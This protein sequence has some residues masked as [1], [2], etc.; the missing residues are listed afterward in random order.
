[1]LDVHSVV[2]DIPCE[3]DMSEPLE[4]VPPASWSFLSSL[5]PGN[6]GIIARATITMQIFNIQNHPDYPMTAYAPEGDPQKGL[7][8]IWKP[9]C[10]ILKL[11][12]FVW[13]Y[14]NFLFQI[15][16]TDKLIEVCVFSAKNDTSILK[17]A[18]ANTQII[19]RDSML[20]YCNLSVDIYQHVAE[21]LGQFNAITDKTIVACLPSNKAK[22][23]KIK[24]AQPN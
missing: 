10:F 18:L 2:I 6:N 23:Y 13:W 22:N 9:V 15:F 7:V 24:Y 5:F 8:F 16:Q 19:N 12:M 17:R 1:M 21:I 11:C 20:I 14:L 4:V 3:D